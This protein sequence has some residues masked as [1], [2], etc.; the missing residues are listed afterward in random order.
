VHRSAFA[1]VPFPYSEILQASRPA[2][3]TARRTVSG[4]VALTGLKS[5]SAMHN[6]L[7]RELPLEVRPSGIEHALCHPSPSYL[8]RAHI[9]DD[10]QP[11]FLCQRG[12]GLV[13]EILAAVCDLGVNV[14]HAFRFAGA[15]RGCERCLGLA[16]KTGLLN[17]VAVA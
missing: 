2:P 12:A 5:A 14:P 7:V 17:L 16:V 1:A 6:C 10:D 11:V 15:L 3:C 9:A 8:R 13:H 4:S